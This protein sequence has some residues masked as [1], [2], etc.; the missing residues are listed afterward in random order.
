MASQGSSFT[1]GPVTLHFPDIT[2]VAGETI[3]G[4]VDLNVAQAQ[5]DNVE[6]ITVKFKGTIRCKITTGSGQSR[7]EHLET[8]ILFNEKLTLWERGT[9]FPP[10]GS[11]ILPCSFQFTLPDTAPPSFHCEAYHRKATISYA[12]EVVGRRPGLFRFNRNIRRPISVIPA[13]SQA[14]LLVTESLRQ[15]WSGRYRNWTNEEK[16]RQGIWGDY[17]HARVELKIPDLASYPI[18]TAIPFSLHVETDT[19]PFPISDAPV[20]KHGKPLFPAPPAISSEVR[21]CLVRTTNLRVRRYSRQVNDTFDLKGSVGDAT[22][23]AAVH[24]ATDEPEWIPALG[25]KD[26]KGLGTWRRAVHFESAVKIPY[27]PTTHA[28]IVD[29]QYYLR[30]IIPFPGIGNDLQLDVPLNLHSSSACPPPPVGV[31]GSSNTTYADVIPAG[32]PPPMLDLPP[33]YFTGEHHVW[34]GDEKN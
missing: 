14:Q 33:S 30:I 9:T 10:P 12:L 6:Q 29:W 5:E 20:D 11:H 23:V 17:S 8:L 4:Y 2:R 22:R 25:P 34:D 27:T 13:A 28:E 32:P 1:D 24:Q 16:L 3:S 26:K 15:G 7:R 31:A 19:K 21:L 18:A